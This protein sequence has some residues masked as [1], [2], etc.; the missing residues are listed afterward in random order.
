MR[1]FLLLTLL[2]TAAATPSLAQDGGDQ[3]RG[4]G[5]RLRDAVEQRRSEPADS[6]VRAE[7][8][9]QRQERQQQR[10][11]AVQPRSDEQV[12]V[13]RVERAERL[14]ERALRDRTLAD[15]TQPRG[16]DDRLRD[17]VAIER[18]RQSGD[19]RDGQRDRD[20]NR[21]WREGHRRDGDRW[22]KADRRYD[23][24]WRHDWR[25]DGRYDWRGHRNRHR[26]LYRFGL[27]YDPFGY[28]YR[29]YNVGWPIRSR[30]WGSNYW[31]QDPWMYRLPPA[32]GPY[33]WVR[34]W[35]DALL[36][37]TRTGRVVDVIYSVF[38]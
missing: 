3:R 37:D 8:Q 17:A 26:S 15:T 19:L 1:N 21:S 10:V 4:F 20:R 5:D 12:Q 14:R 9:Q 33:R 22:R 6:S 16:F 18:A 11:Q 13:R 30:Y 25:Q 23:H 38:W 28:S 24:N 7:R 34:Y 2:A 31:I 32:Y 27:Y 35:D 29:P 36:I